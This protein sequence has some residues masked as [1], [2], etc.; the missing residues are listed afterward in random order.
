MFN[1]AFLRQVRAV[2]IELIVAHLPAGARVLEIG[3]GT[4]QQAIALR[5]RGFEVEAIEVPDSNYSEHQLFP[6]TPYDGRNIPFPD[7]SFDVVFSSNVLEHVRDLGALESE[8]KRVMRPDAICVHVMPTH[9]WRFWH[10]LAAFPAGVQ[11]AIALARAPRPPAAPTK[12]ALRPLVT[13]VKMVGQLLH[14]F[15]QGRHGERGLIFSE[16]WLFHPAAW[17]RH[18]RKHGFEI[19]SD[20][21]VGIFHT[22][23]FVFGARW[24]FERRARLA[25]R[26]GSASHL[27]K[28]RA[29]SAGPAQ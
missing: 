14:P 24:S 22:G 9:A 26:L 20:E 3:A 1:I 2:E 29:G 5:E 12:L 27:F 15:I 10:T 21:P 13:L 7:A 17:R 4:G 23:H 28:L 11:E 19:I 8:I 16:L 6:I 25:K 18:F